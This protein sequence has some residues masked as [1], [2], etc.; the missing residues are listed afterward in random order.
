M[1]EMDCNDVTRA[2]S[3]YVDGEL[4]AAA[5]AALER[6]LEGC[7]DCRLGV[8]HQRELSQLVRRG[9]QRFAAPGHLAGRIGAA[10]DA[11]KGDARV[12]PLRRAAW[13]PLALAASFVLAMILSSG[14][15]W[16]VAAYDRQDRLTQEVVSSHV[17]ALLSNRMIDI[18]S[19]DQHT[20][21]PWFSGKLDLAPPVRDLTTAGFPLV[22]GRLDYV[23]QRPVAALVYRHNQHV[24]DLFILPGDAA[25][26]VAPPATSRQGY[27]LR[28]WRDGGMT[29]WAISDLAPE[30]LDKFELAVRAPAN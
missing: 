4:D 9:A 27:A 20:V 29:F 12:V 2:S 19:S 21:K 1:T 14:A 10:L 23:G 25:P 28:R 15:T 11:A 8:E 6:H 24:I 22:G 16:L 7:A 13:R 5:V 30:D 3:S 18:A 17:R 26:G